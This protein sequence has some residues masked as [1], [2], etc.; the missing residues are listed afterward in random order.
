MTMTTEDRDNA[1]VS[2][3]GVGLISF[4]VL[5]WM[6]AVEWFGI[7]FRVVGTRVEY[8]PAHGLPPPSVAFLARHADDVW[9]VVLATPTRLM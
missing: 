2:V 4:R 8:E 3:A 7:R 1:L 6:K 9:R 5:T